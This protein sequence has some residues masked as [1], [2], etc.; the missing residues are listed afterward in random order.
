MGIFV[1]TSW[2]YSILIGIGTAIGCD[3]ALIVISLLFAFVISLFIDIS[4]PVEGKVKPFYRIMV[5]QYCYGILKVAGVKLNI[6]GKELLPDDKRFLLV[7]NHKSNFDPIL[8]MVGLRKYRIAFI[9]KPSNLKIPIAGGFIHKC[10]FLAIDRESPMKSLRTLGTASKYIENDE[11]SIGI[12]PEGTRSKTGELQK[13]HDGVFMVAKNTKCPIVVSTIRGTEDVKKNFPFKRTNVEVRI[14]K[15]IYPEEF[16]DMRTTAMSN[17]ARE[18]IEND[19][20]E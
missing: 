17:Y 11:A 6:I 5:E 15:V 3:V 13:F 20:K 19:L 8:Y 7:A 4:K 10:K 14:V 2:Y 1:N 12:F 16:A 18:F 9:S